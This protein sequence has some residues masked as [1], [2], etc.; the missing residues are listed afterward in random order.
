M[1]G[2]QQDE[3]FRVVYHVQ[4]EHCGT[5]QN[6]HIYLVQDGTKCRFPISHVYNDMGKQ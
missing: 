6:R 3:G 4:R 1:L 2:G 5:I